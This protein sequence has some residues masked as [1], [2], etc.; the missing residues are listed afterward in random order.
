MGMRS[1]IGLQGMS[2]QELKEKIAD[3]DAKIQLLPPYSHQQ[4]VEYKWKTT[5]LNELNYALRD[6]L[7]SSS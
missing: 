2:S 4:L 6:E 3:V 1:G 5:L 7:N